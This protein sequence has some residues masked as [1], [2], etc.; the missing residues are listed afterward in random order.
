MRTESITMIAAGRHPLNFI[1][2]EPVFQ[3][4]GSNKTLTSVNLLFQGR[5][6]TKIRVCIPLNSE[7]SNNDLVSEV[8]CEFI[9]QSATSPVTTYSTTKTRKAHSNDFKQK[10]AQKNAAQ[11]LFN[12]YNL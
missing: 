12:D 3:N 7:K 2:Y 1:E 6:L 9:K 10:E 8:V 4:N 11:N 5:I